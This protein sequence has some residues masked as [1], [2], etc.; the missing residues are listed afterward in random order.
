MISDSQDPTDKIIEL[1][2][3]TMTP[4]ISKVRLEFDRSS[5]ESIVPN[6]DKIPYILKND[7]ANFYITFN[8][9]LEHPQIFKFEYEDSTIKLPYMS[10][11]LVNPEQQDSF[12]VVD[13]MAHFRVL[14]SL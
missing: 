3:E 7:I 13:K 6:P 5:V 11:I 12:P 2:D 10:E 8:K 9:P 4:L 14:R 1:L